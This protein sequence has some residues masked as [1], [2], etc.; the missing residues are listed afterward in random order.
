MSDNLAALGAPAQL[1][2]RMQC[3]EG[4]CLGSPSCSSAR[5]RR[6]RTCCTACS[7]APCRCTGR[8]LPP[9][10]RA[11]QPISL[12]KTYR[13][14]LNSNM[15][16]LQLRCCRQH[17][18]LPS[19]H[20]RSAKQGQAGRAAGC[21]WRFLAM[22]RAAGGQGIAGHLLEDAERGAHVG[23]DLP[24]PAA[25]AAR[26]G[27]RA[28]LRAAAL[29]GSAVLQAVHL[30]STNTAAAER[31]M[32]CD[33]SIT[34]Q[35]RWARGSLAG[36]SH[37]RSAWARNVEACPKALA[38]SRKTAP[39][40]WHSSP[41]PRRKPMATRQPVLLQLTTRADAADSVDASCRWQT[42]QMRTCIADHQG[43]P[44]HAC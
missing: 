34:C 4:D 41:G 38:A 22:L 29:A 35:W 30:R 32:L 24:L 23:H 14:A 39:T 25:L 16:S 5:A 7:A 21:Q 2:A 11:H 10:C 37:I 43:S 42:P 15:Q 9:A 17:G 20:N 19:T 27:R 13:R 6:R 12:Q 40:R 26:A 33:A 28:G 18:L 44:Q 8:T 1:W 36:G 31:N 3:V